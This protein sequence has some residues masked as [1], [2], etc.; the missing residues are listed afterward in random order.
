MGPALSAA[1]AGGDFHLTLSRTPPIPVIP[2]EAA[3]LFPSSFILSLSKG[4]AS[5]GREVYL[6]WQ[7]EESLFDLSRSLAGALVRPSYD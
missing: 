2:T 1:L 4:E 3:S 6:P 5:T 7:V